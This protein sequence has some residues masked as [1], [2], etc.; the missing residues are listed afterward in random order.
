VDELRMGEVPVLRDPVLLLAFGGWSDAG[1]AATGAARFLVNA[2]SAERLGDIDPEEFYNFADL[3]PHVRVLDGTLRE[4]EWPANECFYY[5]ARGERDFVVLVGVEPHLRWRRFSDIV[6][7]IVQRCGVTLAFTLGGLQA[8]VPHSRPLR[9]TGGS[10]DELLLARMSGVVRTGGGRY[11]GPT[12]ITGVLGERFRRAGLPTAT[13]WANVPHYIN[14]AINPKAI[15][16]LLE[17]L[18][19]VFDL[20]LDLRELHHTAERFDREV[21]EAV[22]GDADATAYVR[23]LEERADAEAREERPSLPSG[24]AIVRELE[25]F[26]RRSQ[27]NREE[28]S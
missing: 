27:E 14:A 19:A 17:R 28:Q 5:R 1:Q 18:D 2:W 8:D 3:R 6:L 24:E 4:L 12:G 25:E 11:E 21:S 26:L 13:M 10:S 7:E 15:A 23:Q 9:V 20:A 16:A 22:A